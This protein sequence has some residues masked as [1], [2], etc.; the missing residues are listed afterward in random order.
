MA[1]KVREAARVE[2]LTGM[3]TEFSTYFDIIE[4][5]PRM[6]IGKQV[7]SLDP[8][9]DTEVIRDAN[10]ARDYQEA[11][12][13]L[14][15]KELGSRVTAAVQEQGEY[16]QV[17]SQSID[18][19]QQNPDL[20]RDKVLADRV[21][22]LIKPYEYR[23]DG[24]LVGYSV[25][26]IPLVAQ[27]RQQLQTERSTAG[28][29]STGASVPPVAPAVPTPPAPAPQQGLRASAAQSSQPEGFDQLWST[30]GFAPGSIN[31]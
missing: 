11:A 21:A 1:T 10:D 31:L 29:A 24:K 4:A 8:E 13:S 19:L 15:A 5:A 6:L 17:V 18:M 30:L 28:A 23:K 2:T 22:A 9:K 25:N 7:P 3:R 26:V 16:L 27:V 20:L 14:L 12:K